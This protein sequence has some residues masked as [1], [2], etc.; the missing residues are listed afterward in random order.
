[1][2]ERKRP[3]VALKPS[4]PAS[5]LAL[6]LNLLP[7]YDPVKRNSSHSLYQVVEGALMQLLLNDAQCR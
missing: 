6:S 5:V 2:A 7:A 3:M 1:M 4:E